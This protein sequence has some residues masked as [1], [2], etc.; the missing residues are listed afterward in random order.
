MLKSC[1]SYYR[2]SIFGLNSASLKF[3]RLFS[4][5]INVPTLGIR[6]DVDGCIPEVAWELVSQKSFRNGLT[7][8]V[9]P[10]VGH[11]TQLENRQWI[12]ERLVGWVNQHSV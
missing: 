4:G 10:G 9:I 5:K 6:V 11:F 3:G 12:S 1:L 8:E 7:L 2:N